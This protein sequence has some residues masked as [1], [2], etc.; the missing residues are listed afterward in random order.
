MTKRL[1]NLIH[2]LLFVLSMNA[3]DLWVLQR[4]LAQL[5]DGHLLQIFPF[6]TNLR[7]PLLQSCLMRRNSYHRQNGDSEQ[8]RMLK[9][10]SNCHHR[11]TEMLAF[12]TDGTN[13]VVER[14]LVLEE[15]IL[16]RDTDKI[17]HSA[18]R[19]DHG[20]DP[21]GFAAAGRRIVRQ[22]RYITLQA[23]GIDPLA[24][25]RD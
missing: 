19:S 17:I 3:H 20:H 16:G 24:V 6:H 25:A 2:E 18:V 5:K 12:E 23:A 8:F 9:K 11:D 1:R 4:F 13:D 15:V 7:S 21:V 14:S 10:S 22:L